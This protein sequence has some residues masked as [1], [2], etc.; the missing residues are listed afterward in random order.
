MAAM[1]IPDTRSQPGCTSPGATR[2]GDAGFTLLEVLVAFVIA[3]L[4]LGVLFEGAVEGIRSARIADRTQE[5]M[6]RA[7]SH[8]AT[9]GH[10]VALAPST[11]EGEDG[12]GFHWNLRI[13]PL[14]SATIGSTGGSNNG[15]N[16]ASNNSG[17]GPGNAQAPRAVLYAVQ[18]TESWPD[19][20]AAGDHTRSV[21]LRTERVGQQ[22]GSGP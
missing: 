14:Q 6:S 20:A 1:L 21:T 13:V 16:G 5:A 12:S 8:L 17:T 11:Q 3:A 2:S 4:A 7:Q 9:V 18:I 10:G 15:M 22:Q 19:E